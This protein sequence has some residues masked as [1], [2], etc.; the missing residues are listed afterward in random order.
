MW[1]LWWPKWHFDFPLTIVISAFLH[2]PLQSGAGTISLQFNSDATSRIRDN[3]YQASQLRQ[4]PTYFCLEVL[5][6]NP[7]HDTD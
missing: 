3:P 2:A 7:D 5:A 6:S 1:D 4:E